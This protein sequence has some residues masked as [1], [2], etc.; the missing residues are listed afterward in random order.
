MRYTTVLFDA[1]NTLLD[2]SASE[3]QAHIK[4]SYKYGLPWSEDLYEK[5]SAINDKWWKLYE[6]ELYGR[7]E[8]VVNRYKEYLGLLNADRIDAAAFNDDYRSFL[9]EGRDL[10]EGA[11]Q[12]VKAIKELGA[13]IY[14]VTN[15]STKVQNKRLSG[16]E[17]MRYV[18]GVFIS[19]S[20][21][22]PKPDVE[23]FADLAK[24][25]GVTYDEKTI[26]IGDSLSSDIKGGNNVNIDTCWF[27]YKNAKPTGD[28]K[29]TYEINNLIEAVKIVKG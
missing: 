28:V 4:T 7:E 29:I 9:A 21:G 13:K 18:D 20:S 3:K 23:F 25:F 2:F 14:I 11:N 10:I 26:I 24:T 15:G 6:K 27:N 22:H 1:D 5:Y 8:I 19:E 16:Q 12:T 17:F